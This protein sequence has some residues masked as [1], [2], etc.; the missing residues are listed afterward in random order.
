M[1]GNLLNQLFRGG[2]EAFGKTVHA[3]KHIRSRARDMRAQ[4]RRRRTLNVE[5]QA[6]LKVKKVDS[7]FRIWDVVSK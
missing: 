2:S 6:G 1:A 4:T 3:G 5:R 7:D